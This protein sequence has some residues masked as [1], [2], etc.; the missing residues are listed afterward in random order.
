[1]GIASWNHAN[2]EACP[3]DTVLGETSLQR[4]ANFLTSGSPLGGL[5][6]HIIPDIAKY[7]GILHARDND[8]SKLQPSRPQ[9]DTYRN[10]GSS[11]LF[12]HL[13]SV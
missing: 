9:E 10:T 12:T 7:D 13:I 1:M 2:V 11:D 5:E 4:A 6:V 8:P 3:D